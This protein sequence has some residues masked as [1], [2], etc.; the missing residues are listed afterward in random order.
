VVEST[1]VTVETKVVSCVMSLL[2]WIVSVVVTTVVKVVVVTG[3]VMLVVN[4]DTD[5]ETGTNCAPLGRLA[6]VVVD[7]IRVLD[8]ESVAASSS[9]RPLLLTVPEVVG[10]L[11]SSEEGIEVVGLEEDGGLEE[12]TE[13]VESAR[14]K[15]DGELED[16][17]L[18]EKAKL[19]E[20]AAPEEDAGVREEGGLEDGGVE[21]DGGPEDARLDECAMVSAGGWVDIDAAA[22]VVA[23]CRDTLVELP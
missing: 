12:D 16:V 5:T 15:E 7:M 14:E 22:A 13:L 19:D 17:G 4:L 8:K 23:P 9:L 2:N 11:V 21:E 6:V 1:L 18:E 20:D 10:F 3:T